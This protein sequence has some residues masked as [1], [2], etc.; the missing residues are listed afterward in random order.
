[1]EYK[2]ILVHVDSGKA[3]PARLDLACR[4]A[5]R[6]QAHLT[7]VFTITPPNMP[8]YMEPQ[9]GEDILRVQREAAL[10]AA[11]KGESLFNDAVNANAVSSSEFR[12][13]E[14]SMI[15]VLSVSARYTDLLIVG[16]SNP[17]EDIYTGGGVMPDEL[18]LSVGQPVLVV[19]Y[20]GTFTEIGTQ[21][22]VPWDSSR[23]AARAIG[24]A[25]PFLKTARAVNV[26]TINPEHS[27]ETHG[28]QAGADICTH[29][30]RHGVKA[31]AHSSMVPDMD[32]DA[33][34]LSRA[35]DFGADLIVMGAYGHSRL[36]ELFLGGMTKQMLANMTVP[37]LMSH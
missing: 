24:S 5:N 34:A 23:W 32:T 33:V 12:S 17:D 25:M 30:A 18:V 27:S 19:P 3:C 7:A 29:L 15:E 8:S 28:A 21:V 2:D 14:G 11:S 36:R 35:A 4:L 31:T 26:L 6:F 37:V 10:A 20:A 1:M 9:L 13:D 16:Q 22:M